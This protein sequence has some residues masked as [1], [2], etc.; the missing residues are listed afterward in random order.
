M[1][2]RVRV[3]LL[4]A[5]VLGCSTAPLAA[6]TPRAYRADDL[7]SFGGLDLVGLAINANG[8]IAGYGYLTDGTIRA[9]R[10]TE[11]GGLE[12]LGANGGWL[13]QGIAINDNGDVA[14]L[15]LDQF[16]NPHGFIA[17]CGGVMRDLRTPERQIVRVNSITNDGR[18]AGQMFNF[19]PSFQV[20]AF[21]TLSD[22]TLQDLG[23]GIR[24]SVAWRMNDAGQ[25]TGYEA[26]DATGNSQSAFR[27]S[28]DAG[29]VDLG[30]LGGPR[31]S[32]LAI[33]K[34]G[35]VVGWSEGLNGIWSR[36]FR[37]RPGAP[38]EDLGTLGGQ[39]AGAEGLNDLGTVVG[40]SA[41]P[42]FQTAFVY[43][44]ADGMIDLSARV[45]PLEQR[46]VMYDAMAINNS[47]QIVA[48]Y[49]GPEGTRTVRLTPVV[50]TQ[51]PL[52]TVA[53]ASPDVLYP[54]DGRLVP[55]VVSAS[56]TDDIDDSP[57]CAIVNVTNSEAASAG[58]DPDV[59]VSGPLSVSLRASRLGTA[60]GRT[61]TVKVG[62]SDFSGNKATRDVFVLVPHDN[63]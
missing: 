14:G 11:S 37:A 60:G 7:G 48:L 4:V 55:I 40:W 17:P 10:W 47:G 24:A 44:D 26:V 43:T 12:D 61:Y 21:R 28:D 41:G 27:F 29:I 63:R 34:S 51:S 52:I 62:C 8:E 19:I 54:P 31:S 5:L 56:A 58:L 20:H 9:F 38:M 45:F 2:V 6:Q 16:N 39:Y 25:V 3:L 36:A 18:I 13:S 42:Y 30:T 33:N 15:Y 46:G 53:A 59:Q 32:G 1:S 23:D 49:Y 50:D 22:G 35:V 57:V